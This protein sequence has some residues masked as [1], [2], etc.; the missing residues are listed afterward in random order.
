MLIC[1]RSIDQVFLDVT[2]VACIQQF[3]PDTS[4][5]LIR[6]SFVGIALQVARLPVEVDEL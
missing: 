1:F 5:I 3:C 2:L 4:P 6:D